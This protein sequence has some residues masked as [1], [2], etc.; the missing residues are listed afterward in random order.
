[1]IVHGSIRDL[2]ALRR[3]KPGSPVEMLQGCGSKDR[4]PHGKLGWKRVVFD[5][6]GASEL[7]TPVPGRLIWTCIEAC[8]I[9]RTGIGG[10]PRRDRRV[11][12]SVDS[13][14]PVGVIDGPVHRSERCA[15]VL[16]KEEEEYIK[17][18]LRS[19]LLPRTACCPS[20]DCPPSSFG[21]RDP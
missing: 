19:S 11:Q 5:P 2:H 18:L 4:V 14:R 15:T 6:V 17:S 20:N 16:I 8:H 7:R 13:I 21:R 9:G 1:M 10:T 12:W 3:V